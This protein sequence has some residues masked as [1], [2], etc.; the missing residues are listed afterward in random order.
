MFPFAAHAQVLK[1]VEV[2]AP[3]VNCVFQTD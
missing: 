3:A 1:V 2:G